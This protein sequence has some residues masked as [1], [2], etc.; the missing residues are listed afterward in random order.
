VIDVHTHPGAERPDL[1]FSE[2][3]LREDVER[4]LRAGVTA[5]RSPGL[6][7]DAPP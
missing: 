7:V 5:I 4:H 3:T 2:A 6:A 1:P